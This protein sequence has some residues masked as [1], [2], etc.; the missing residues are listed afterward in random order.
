MLSTAKCE[1]I[2]FDLI[3]KRRAD[4]QTSRRRCRKDY[5]ARAHC[6]LDNP[7]TMLFCGVVFHHHG[8][9]VV[10]QSKVDVVHDQTAMEEKIG[11]TMQDNKQAATT[12]T[13]VED[14]W[15]VGWRLLQLRRLVE[16]F[17]VT[18]KEDDDSVLSG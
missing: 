8:R 9:R 14:L 7:E 10:T 13:R 4:V 6:R 12:C 15:C 2:A 11:K 3:A 18:D 16:P 17:S 5:V 1:N